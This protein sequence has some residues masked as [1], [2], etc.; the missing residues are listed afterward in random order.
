MLH[1]AAPC[2]RWCRVNQLISIGILPCFSRVYGCLH[3]ASMVQPAMPR[4]GSPSLTTTLEGCGEMVPLSMP[5][6]WHH[7]TRKDLRNFR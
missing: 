1:H 4:C 5:A 2:F 7:G 3:H 6:I